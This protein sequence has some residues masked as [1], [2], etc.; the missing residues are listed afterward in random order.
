[1]RKSANMDSQVLGKGKQFKQEYT[2]TS[3]FR[4]V[5]HPPLCTTSHSIRVPST[6]LLRRLKLQFVPSMQL[7][8]RR[9]RRRRRSLLFTKICTLTTICPISSNFTINTNEEVRQHGLTSVGEGQA[10]QAGIHLHEQISTSTPSSSVHDVAFYS[11]PFHRAFETA[12]IAIRSLDAACE[13]AKP[14]SSPLLALHED[15]YIDDDLSERNFGRLCMTD[16]DNYAYVWP[17][18][19]LDSTHTAFDVE[20]VSDV[21]TRCIKFIERVDSMCDED[22]INVIFGHADTLQIMQAVC[23]GLE[24]IGEFSSYRFKNGEVRELFLP[25][26]AP[27]PLEKPD[28]QSK[29]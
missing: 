11:S 10:V 17:V 4:Q 1:M 27:V 29:L 13:S 21:A 26:P 28:R 2:S 5:P 3:K 15:L 19:R 16:I 9:N 14:S 25:L 18:D 22:T 24:N 7:A 12:E 8:N 23:S 20:S 6:E